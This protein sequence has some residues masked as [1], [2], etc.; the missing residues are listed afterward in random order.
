MRLYAAATLLALS[1]SSATAWQCKHGKPQH[2]WSSVGLSSSAE[3]SSPPWTENA[4]LKSSFLKTV[5]DREGFVPARETV[6]LD[7]PPIERWV[8]L[9]QKYSSQKDLIIQY[10]EDLLPAPVVAIIAK[11][12]AQ[13]I[14]YPGFGQY[15]DEMRGY[16]QGLGLDLGFVVAANLVYE[17]ESIGV[18]CDNWNNTGPTGQCDGE[19][20]DYFD[21][22]E[23][24]VGWFESNHYKRNAK[25]VV[26]TGTCTSV[27][28][29]N[30]K[31][32]IL[33]GR[34]L[35]WNLPEELRSLVLTV[36]FMKN[37]ELLYTGTTVVSFVGLLN[38]MKPEAFTYSQ[39]ARCQGGMLLFNLLE[40]LR[41]GADTPE[42]RARSVFE[43]ASTYEESVAGFSAGHLITDAYFIVG[44]KEAG[45]GA[46]VSRAR[47]RAVDVWSIP[48]STEPT[49]SMWY[50]LQTNYDHSDEPP[51]AD[52]R[53][54]PGFANM[55]AVGKENLNEDN[56]LK[57]VM[58]VWPTY[59]PHTDLT[60]IMAAHGS[61]YD[62]LV[63][64]DEQQ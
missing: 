50:R 24:G 22:E 11:V 56:L 43:S 46:V 12:A 37:N 55:D 3:T 41:F 19:T 27:V 5:G 49:D 15:G 51:A 61:V 38:A 42:Q 26:Q 28:A 16:A 30:P 47:N 33:H 57:D 45:E 21:D 23:Q 40:A 60:C 31:G 63:W 17:L 20:P 9:G 52:D 8:A 53:E 10:F 62:C 58:T 6:N 7:L 4:S 25:D 39:N 48:V 44:G 59:N 14:D 1:L 36:D 29:N 64:K 35:D 54:T 13:L 32:G 18:T 2:P 34:N